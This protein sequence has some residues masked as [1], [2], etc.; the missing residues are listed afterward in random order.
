MWT[1]SVFVCGSLTAVCRKKYALLQMFPD[2]T[3]TPSTVA[4]KEYL[5]CLSLECEEKFL[6]PTLPRAHLNAVDLGK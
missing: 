4:I 1:S 6:L 5:R 2:S 3:F